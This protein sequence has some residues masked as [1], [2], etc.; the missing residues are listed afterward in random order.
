[1]RLFD[2][3]LVPPLH[4]AVALEQVRDV[5][6]AIADHLHLDVTRLVDQSL[7]IDLA[8]G[9]TA[10]GHRGRA[11]HHAE[12]FLGRTRWQHSD[13]AAPRSRLDQNWIAD[14]LGG[15]QHLGRIAGQHTGATPQRPAM[16]RRQFA[17]ARLVPHR[18]DPARRWADKAHPGRLNTGGKAG[19]FRKK[20]IAGM[21]RVGVMQTRHLEQPILIQVALAGW[22]ST[23]VRGLAGQ[24]QVRRMPVGIGV[25]GERRDA[26]R[27]ECAQHARGDRS[28]VGDN[29]LVEQGHGIAQKLVGQARIR[30]WPTPR[31]RR[32]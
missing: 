19:V 24:F 1:M 27:I 29:D 9:E 22:R 30:C 10:L 14:L 2:D 5:A 32:N 20:S 17:R 16:A 21:Q 26:Q 28:T 4:R 31:V 25:Q 23:D 12:Q 13:S 18:L 7:Q 3:L 6:V 8:A 11:L 15:T